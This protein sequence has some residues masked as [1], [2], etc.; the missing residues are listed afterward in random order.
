MI[1]IAAFINGVLTDK[2]QV[3]SEAEIPAAKAELLRFYPEATIY[4]KL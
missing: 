4:R 2:I 1:T 3:A